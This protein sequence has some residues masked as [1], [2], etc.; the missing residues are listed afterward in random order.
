MDQL[1]LIFTICAAIGGGLFLIRLILQLV[2]FTFDLPSEQMGDVDLSS[3]D[4]SFKMLS[5][6]GAVAF[7][8][9][10]GLAGR[11]M[12]ATLPGQALPALGVAVAAGLFST[13]MIAKMF[14]L[15][16][17]LQSGGLSN[18]QNAV[19]REGTVYLNIPANDTGKVKISVN[20]RLSVLDARSEKRE[21]IAT[22]TRV[23]V[24]RVADGNNLMVEAVNQEEN[25]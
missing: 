16:M 11:A 6:L 5:V 24:V 4:A 20:G 21:T 23:R 3:T 12:L 19:G 8:M 18:P 14:T 25:A 15:M 2:G 10:F 9:M 17:K 22:G 1:E 7:L 13:W